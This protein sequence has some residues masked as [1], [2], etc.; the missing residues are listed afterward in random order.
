[1]CWFVAQLYVY[2]SVL[3]FRDKSPQMVMNLLKADENVDVPLTCPAAN[4]PQQI[5]AAQPK[6]SIKP[7]VH[8]HRHTHTHAH[9]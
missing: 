8:T 4:K 5:V 9:S 7:K 6:T 1:M 2:S 3:M